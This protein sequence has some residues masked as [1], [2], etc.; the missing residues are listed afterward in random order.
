MWITR[1]CLFIA[2]RVFNAYF[3]DSIGETGLGSWDRKHL[4]RLLDDLHSGPDPWLFLFF[5]AYN[6]AILCMTPLL[7]KAFWQWARFHECVAV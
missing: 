5:F 1:N 3:H 6:I 7:P 4:V 2:M